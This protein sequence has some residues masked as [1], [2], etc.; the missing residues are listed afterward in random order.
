MGVNVSNIRYVIH[1]GPSADDDYVQEA[2]RAGRDNT[3]SYAIIYR[4]PYELMGHA[5][6][7]MKAYVRLDKG[8]RR[9]FLLNQF[10]S[11]KVARVGHKHLCCDLCTAHCHCDSPCPFK[12]PLA[13]TLAITH[14]FDVS[15]NPPQVRQLTLNQRSLLKLKLMELRH[16]LL[17]ASYDHACA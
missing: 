13:E 3:L 2:G 1:Y 16:S 7:T 10:T 17:V 8:C 9:N 12:P 14:E 11:E 6:K 4:Y 5:S 15:V